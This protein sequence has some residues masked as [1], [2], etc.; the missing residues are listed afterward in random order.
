MELQ[1]I[2][3]KL[4]VVSERLIAERIRRGQIGVAMDEILKRKNGGRAGGDR[5]VLVEDVRSL[6]VL[7]GHGGE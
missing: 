1:H 3:A 2:N 6:I 4:L 7:R 5:D